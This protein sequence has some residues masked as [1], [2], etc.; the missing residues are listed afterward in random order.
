M[1]IFWRLLDIRFLEILSGVL[2]TFEGQEH[3]KNIIFLPLDSCLMFG[4]IFSNFVSLGLA[5]LG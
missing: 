1:P 2:K 3:L 4:T 5:M